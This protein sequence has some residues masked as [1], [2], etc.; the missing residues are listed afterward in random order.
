MKHQDVRARVIHLMEEMF[1][2]QPGSV[3]PQ[4]RLFE[5]LDLDSLDAIDM[6]VRLQDLTGQ[7]VSEATLRQIR[8]VQDI[9]NVVESHLP[10]APP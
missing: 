6:V 5:D 3:T 7:R 10:Q 4:S 2:L 9:I 8:T 1:E